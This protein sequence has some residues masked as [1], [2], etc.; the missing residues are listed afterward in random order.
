MSSIRWIF[1]FIVLTYTF[2]N[3][4]VGI[5]A[6]SNEKMQ[7]TFDIDDTYFGLYASSSYIG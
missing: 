1:A 3:I 7:S 5:L 4:D 6:V 2:C